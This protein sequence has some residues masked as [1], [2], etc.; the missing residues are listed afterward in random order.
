MDSGIKSVI[1][2]QL[3]TPA[4][5]DNDPIK[6]LSFFPLKNIKKQ[7]NIVERPARL[8]IKNAYVILFMSSPIK[9]MLFYLNYWKTK[10]IF[11]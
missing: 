5:K 7:P 2:T 11:V 8:H 6:I 10:A 4:A 1:E 3:I 9:F